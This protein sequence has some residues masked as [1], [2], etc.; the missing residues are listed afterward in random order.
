MINLNE[1]IEIKATLYKPQI[2]CKLFGYYN[3]KFYRTEM[4]LKQMYKNKYAGKGYICAM[5]S[6]K[7]VRC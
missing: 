2:N 6:F 5:H 3:S 1:I 7:A 4:S